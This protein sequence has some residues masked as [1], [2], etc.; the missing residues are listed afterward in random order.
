[1]R[2]KFLA[3]SLLLACVVATASASAKGQTARVRIAVLNFGETATGTR[4]AD[5]IRRALMINPSKD[6]VLT[7]PDLARAA[8]MGAGYDGSLNLTIDDARNIGAAVGV[9]FYFTGDA[10]TVRRSPSTGKAYYESF[11]AIFLVSARTGRLILWERPLE[12]RD[13]ARESYE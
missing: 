8:A 5:A 3:H 9:D 1:M 13:S 4:A 11:A 10:Q 2:F 6:F 12:R 7:D